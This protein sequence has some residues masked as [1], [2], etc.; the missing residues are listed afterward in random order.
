MNHSSSWRDVVVSGFA[1]FAIFFGAGNLIFPPMLGNITG[2]AW[3]AGVLGFLSTDPV[4]PI[5]AVIATALVGG[6]AHDLGKR[7]SPKFAIILASLCILLIGPILSVPR[8]AA[9]T[10]EFAIKPYISDA[11]ATP[12][13]VATSVIFFAITLLFSLREFR[14]IDIVGIFLTPALL[15]T[16]ALLVVKAV[17]TPIGPIVDTGVSHPYHLGFIE[18][19]QTMDALGGALLCGA[20]LTDLTR[21]GYTDRASQ[22][23]MLIKVG[24][25]AGLLLGL[26]YTGLTYLGATTSASPQE[27][28]VLLLLNSV[29]TLFGQ[30]GGVLLGTAVGLACLTTAVG[31][32]STCGNFFS[33]VSQGK[34]S[35]RLVVWLAAI[36]S[37]LMSLLSVSGIIA[38]AVPILSTIYP[39]VAV[40]VII[41][42]IDAK[43]PYDIMYTG[44]ALVAGVIGFIEAM[45]GSFG[46]FSGVHDLL[47]Q[48]PLAQAGFPWV[49]PA[50]LAFLLAGL[51][52]HAIQARDSRTHY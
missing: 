34:I 32:T 3:T 37:T 43:I 31:L 2:D 13:M 40:L 29:Q 20:V 28:R 23:S 21:K 30:T 5:L 8:T 25:V 19:Y 33:T 47:M 6:R 22:R 12:A 1:L 49:F 41:T 7:V 26:V 36:F 35:Y 45:Y 18:G 52:G 15:I 9:T 11:I 44:P 10:F 39:V 16:M 50:L 46:F 27:D 17:I 38:L 42:L 24:L 14:V 48:I 51:L 4:L